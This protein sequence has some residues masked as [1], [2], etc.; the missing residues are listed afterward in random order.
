MLLVMTTQGV[1]DSFALGGATESF[2]RASHH[3]TLWTGTWNRIDRFLPGFLSELFPNEKPRSSGRGTPDVG[4]AEVGMAGSLEVTQ[5]QGRE[6]SEVGGA[7]KSSSPVMI[8]GEWSGG[9]GGHTP[10]SSPPRG[11]PGESMEWVWGGWYPLWG[12]FVWSVGYL[13]HL[14]VAC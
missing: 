10:Q 4:T 14:F 1:F 5:K 13:C 3:K 2:P 7:S 8:E 11:S 9:S 12:S 6:P